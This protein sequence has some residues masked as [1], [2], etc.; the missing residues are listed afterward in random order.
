VGAK[1][2]NRIVMQLCTGV[3]IRDVVTP[4]NFGSH[5]FR[6][7]QMA[8]RRI[9]GFL[10][11]FQRRPGTYVPACGSK[12]WTRAGIVYCDERKNRFL[13]NV[14]VCHITLLFLQTYYRQLGLAYFKQRSPHFKLLV[15]WMFST[16]QAGHSVCEE[17][18]R[19]HQNYGACFLPP[20]NTTD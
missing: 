13:Q 20:G 9:S 16:K 11:D 5:R 18:D 15:V 7:F 4:A 3:D 12:S 2:L 1:S 8:G 6:G 14:Y 10:I 19:A 17:R